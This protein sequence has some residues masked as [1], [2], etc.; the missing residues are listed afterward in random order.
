MVVVE[1]EFCLN[2]AAEIDNPFA[3]RQEQQRD[4]N[5]VTFR[6]QLSVSTITILES[7]IPCVSLIIS[8]VLDVHHDV[9]ATAPTELDV[10][11]QQRSSVTP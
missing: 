2:F 9:R 8:F 11:L 3:A 5:Y 4:M 6:S 7:I 1:Q 10:F